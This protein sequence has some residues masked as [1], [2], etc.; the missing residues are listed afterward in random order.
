MEIPVTPELEK[1][2]ASKVASGTYTSP[3]EVVIA[4]LESLRAEEQTFDQWLLDEVL[5]ALDELEA[6]PSLGIP[7]DVAFAE[8]REYRAL[9]R[10][11]R[12]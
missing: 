10:K 2:V 7:I 12:V 11:A 6:D 8:I 9:H 1:Y 5:P 3:S 4:G